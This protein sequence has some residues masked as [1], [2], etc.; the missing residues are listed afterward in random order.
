M[1]KM[2]LASLPALMLFLPPASVRAETDPFAPPPPASTRRAPT[3]GLNWNLGA[4]SAGGDLSSLLKKPV[5]GELSLFRQRGPWRYGLGL[6]FGSFSMKAPYDKEL[7]WGF[8]QSYLFAT[9]M[10]RTEGSFRP[11]LQ[12]RGGLARLHARSELFNI[13]PLPADYALGNSTTKPANGFS[14]G[15]VPGFEWTLNRSVALDASAAF[16]YY[17]VGETDLSAVGLAP[18]S[19]GTTFEARLGVRW[20]PD[21]GHPS[22]VRP[23]VP[24]DAPRDA[25]GVSQNYDWAAAEVLGINW[26][27]KAVNEYVR[28]GNFNQ[29][30]PR[31][32]WHNIKEGFTYDDNEFRTNQFIHPFNGSAYYNSARGN[33]LGYWTSAGYAAFGAFYWEC[34]GETHPMSINDLVSTGISGIALGEMQYR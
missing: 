25:W 21:N 13:D 8:L 2:T 3:W 10:L 23:D 28:N 18:A 1:T 26:V 11:Y 29:V 4:G 30:S 9:R 7:E 22:G 19:S 31:S 33:G 20:H 6:N 32:W 34:C 5:S 16:T 17:S 12:A 24:D 14:V 27:S 15:L